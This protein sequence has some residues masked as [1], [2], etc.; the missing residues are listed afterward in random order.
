MELTEEMELN[1]MSQLQDHNTIK[2]NKL[3]N[4]KGFTLIELILVVVLVSLITT[5]ASSQFSSITGWRQESEIRYFSSL[6]R[7]LFN[8]AYGRGETYRLVLDIDND[9]YQVFRE[10]PLPPEKAENV[11]LVSNLRTRREK[12]RRAKEDIADIGTLNEE[13]LKQDTLDSTPLDIQYF[14]TRFRDANA[15]V[16]LSI[17]LEFPS[18]AKEKIFSDGLDIVSV[19]RGKETI[20]EGK[21]F[22]RFTPQATS[23]EVEISLKINEQDFVAKSESVN[24][25]LSIKEAS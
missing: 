24:G 23:E 5:L 14:S 3:E 17:P 6:W 8:E 11:D 4:E 16:R 22:F 18:L 7:Q 15:S 2:D 25:N 12:E 9:F 1:R 20:D 19:K 10:I 13:F 21:V